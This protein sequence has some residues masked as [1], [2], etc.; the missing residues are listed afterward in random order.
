M[1]ETDLERLRIIARDYARK[2]LTQSGGHEVEDVAQCAL[3]DFVKY[4]AT[5]EIENPEGL[6]CVMARRRARKYRDDWKANRGNRPLD[7]ANGMGLALAAQGDDPV[8]ALI[9]QKDAELLKYAISQLRPV[10][11]E[12]ARL[13][14]ECDPPLSGPQV[15]ERTGLTAATVR[16][17]LVQIRRLLAELL[18]TPPG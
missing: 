15:A 2:W 17:R 13:T 8:A 4:S 16:N 10:D 14:Y 12:I 6:I 18:E 5:N 11:R 3:M 9:S 7:V 1:T